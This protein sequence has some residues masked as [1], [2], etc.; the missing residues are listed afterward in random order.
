MTFK[1]N[2][3]VT[4]NLPPNCQSGTDFNFFCNLAQKRLRNTLCNYV[5][6]ELINNT[7]IQIIESDKFPRYER[8][9]VARSHFYLLNENEAQMID[10]MVAKLL[11]V[12]KENDK[13]KNKNIDLETA[14]LLA[15]ETSRDYRTR[16]FKLAQQL[17]HYSP[18]YWWHSF[19][20]D[21]VYFFRKSGWWK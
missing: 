11:D 3:E 1:K 17:A 20:N 15:T 12:Q 21:I 10:E 8:K 13:L 6:P 18:S 7:D 2:I 5:E 16:C 9:L 19:R 14:L 4:L